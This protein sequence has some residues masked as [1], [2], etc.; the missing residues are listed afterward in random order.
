MDVILFLVCPLK[1]EL[2]R[3]M[4]MTNTELLHVAIQS[5]KGSYNY[6]IVLGET[7]ESCRGELT[8]N[9]QTPRPIVR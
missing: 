8:C 9:Y 6:K 2:I 5:A 1:F 7:H 3:D 4:L